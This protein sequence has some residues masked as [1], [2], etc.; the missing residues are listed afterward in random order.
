MA[1]LPIPGQDDGKWGQILNDYLSQA[2]NDDGTLKLGSITKS[3]IGLS[4][5]DNTSDTDKPISLAVQEALITK[6]DLVAGA[7]PSNQLPSFVSSING[8]SGN[9]VLT[10]ADVGA[11]ASGTAY[12]KAE[13]D[14]NFSLGDTG[15]SVAFTMSGPFGPY[16]AVHL[17]STRIVTLTG[18]ANVTSFHAATNTSA[19][20]INFV[21]R[22]APSGG[23]YT[24]GWPS[25]LEW[26]N[27]APAPVMPTVANAEMLVTVFWT[28]AAWRA[29]LN[30]IFYP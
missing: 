22:Q 6:A 1:R 30:G 5:V 14:A 18:N 25:S 9:V 23:P 2:H 12:T 28:G 24:L 29:I 26:V 27:D 11:D 3:D 10:A 4:N 17:G 20:S 16:S 15:P 7:V 8:Q 21:I 13:S 19:G